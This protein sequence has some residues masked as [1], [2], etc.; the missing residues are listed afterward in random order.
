[1]LAVLMFLLLSLK[2][3]ITKSHAADFLVRGCC[4]CEVSVTSL[5]KD[6]I[7]QEE[8]LCLPVDNM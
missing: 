8:F 3:V 1:M 7:S 4:R 2:S 5:D 6:K